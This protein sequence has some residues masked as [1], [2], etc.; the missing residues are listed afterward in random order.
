MLV[1]SGFVRDLRDAGPSCGGKAQS[2]SR[3]IAAGLPVP[4]GFVLEHRAFDLVVGELARGMGSALDAL[5]HALGAAATRIT[6]A[7][8]PHELE[9]DVVARARQLG[10]RVVVRS[11][12][13]LED[14]E[15]GS[16]AG[17]FSSHAVAAADVWAAIRAVWASALTPLAVAY[18]RRR[19]SEIAIGV[20]V[21][22]EAA[23]D[24]VTVYTRPPGDPQGDQVVLQRGADSE[25]KLTRVLRS[26]AS[27][28]PADR[29]AVDLALQAERAIGAQA[30]GADVEL[31]QS[32]GDPRETALVQ[33]RP[34]VH[35]RPRELTDPPE[36]IIAPLR[37]GRV[38]TW[39]IAHN[40]DPLSPAQTGLVERV[41]RAGLGAF[42]VRV[43]AGYLYCSPRADFVSPEV[44]R[45]ASDLGV[46]ATELEAK[47]ASFLV[48][49]PAT[50]EEA[51]ERYLAFYSV[52]SGQLAP[53]ISGARRA[54]ATPVRRSSSIEVLL[55]RAARGETSIE[56]VEAQLGDLSPAW[57]V[58]VAPFG[59]RSGLL[60]EAVHLFMQVASAPAATSAAG[61]DSYA[62][63][64]ADLGER[65]DFLFA[66]AQR[67]VRQALLRRADELGIDPDDVFWLPLDEVIAGTALDADRAKRLAAGAR[68]AAARAAEWRMPLVVGG[69]ERTL[70]KRGNAVLR[71]VGCGPRVVGRVVRF[72]SLAQAVFARAGDVVVVR[73]ATPA[74]AVFLGRCSALVSETGG[75]LDHGAAM[76]RELGIPCVVGCDGAWTQLQDGATVVV[77]GDSG[78]ISTFAPAQNG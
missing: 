10:E 28:R 5:G 58:A 55:S 76:A 9:R 56:A 15:H 40:P 11:S 25:L 1:G 18:A 16:A 70:A 67:F 7:E 24:P 26:E 74:L 46:R 27:M 19:G 71:G 65:D 23:G 75:L 32:L 66:R 37:D 36:I 41:E 31:V 17:V 8:L 64:A 2:L 77:D 61:G 29:D 22:A 42:A 53:L 72:Q 57:D 63:L 45:E 39:D 4:S 20:I 33:A 38:W 21:Q 13:T 68:A 35:P 54:N 14:G 59:E 52:W 60:G 51:L 50:I 30:S 44:P 69:A 62:A 73:A 49:P 78:E 12:A 3:L 43:C 47:A 6:T 34:I 48:T